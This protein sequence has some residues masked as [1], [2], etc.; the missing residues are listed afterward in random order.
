MRELALHILDLI[1]NSLRAGAGIIAVDIAACPKND[2]LRITVEDDGV[3]LKVTPDEALNPF[4]TTKT[5]KRTGLGL[6]LFRAT[7]EQAGGRLILA[8]SLLGATGLKV[9]AEM[10]LT[11]VDRHPLGDL[12]GTLASVVYT[13]PDVDFRFHLRL[14]GRDCAIR[15][16]DLASEMDIPRADG[17]ALARAVQERLEQALRNSSVVVQ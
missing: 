11:H 15:V 3:G 7:A 6:S 16:S 2:R 17:L 12:A 14:D 5:G 4:Y 8:K 10:R 1:E 13:A 9:T